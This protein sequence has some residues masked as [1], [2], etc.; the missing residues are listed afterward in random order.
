VIEIPHELDTML[1]TRNCKHLHEY[2]NKD[3]FDVDR[4]DR[5]MKEEFGEKYYVIKKDLEDYFGLNI[6]NVREYFNLID[7][8]VAELYQTDD[9]RIK[10]Y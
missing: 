9:N 8:R 4:L 3:K 7:A 10:D 5:M 1:H 2:L 6:T